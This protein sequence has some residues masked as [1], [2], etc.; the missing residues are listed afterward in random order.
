MRER[1]F[2]LAI[3]CLIASVFPGLNCASKV[4]RAC[5]RVEDCQESAPKIFCLDGFCSEYECHAGKQ[6][7]CYTGKKAKDSSGKEVLNLPCREGV[8]YCRPEGRWSACLGQVTPQV[9]ICDGIDNDCD[10]QVDNVPN[11]GSGACVC[12][13]P[14]SSRACYSGEPD[15]RSTSPCKEGLQYCGTNNRWGACLGQ[16]VPEEEVC[17]GFDNNCDGKVD[18]VCPCITGTTQLCYRGDP[19]VLRSG[20]CKQGTQTCEGGQWQACVGD[21]LP[22]PELCN[23][24]DDDC[25]GLIDNDCKGCQGS[26]SSCPDSFFCCGDICRL[27]S[28]DTLAGCPCSM[29]ADCP[30]GTYEDN[31][32]IFLCCGGRC[33]DTRYDVSHCGACE[34]A[35]P[36]QQG[37]RDGACVGCDRM[38]KPCGSFCCP[39]TLDCCGLSCVDTKNDPTHC[40]VCGCRCPNG[41]FCRDGGC[42]DA[43]GRAIFSCREVERTEEPSSERIFDG[44]VESQ[45]EMDRPERPNQES[46]M[47][48]SASESPMDGLFEMPSE[49]APGSDP[50]PQEEPREIVQSVESIGQGASD[51]ST[52]EPTPDEAHQPDE[53]WTPEPFPDEAHQPD[54]PWMPEPFPDEAHQPDEPWMPEPFPDEAYQ[55]DEPWM[56]EP[57]PDEAYQPDEPWTPEPFPQDGGTGGPDMQVMENTVTLDTP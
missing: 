45:K 26:A 21:I 35:C 30:S 23:G 5:E 42:V 31:Q 32:R 16:R 43:T 2:F 11:G 3:F 49:Q 27:I 17:D 4:G 46:P 12:S 25:D 18:E 41:S 48:G 19:L 20:A 37:C 7:A 38:A 34:Q 6:E 44:G 8:R 53:P 50:R 29:D 36:S 9:E 55:P 51:G 39:E 40:G 22:S 1:A 10:G 56:P 28:T 57:F 54:E 52:P 15:T 47:D 33:K 24:L 14:G 13:T